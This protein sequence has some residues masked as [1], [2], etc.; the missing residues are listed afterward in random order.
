MVRE[1]KWY[2]YVG[3]G[4]KGKGKVSWIETYTEGSG[5]NQRTYSTER[6]S[7]E[8]YVDEVVIVWGDREAPEPTKL[9]PG[10][11]SFPFQ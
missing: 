11:F 1:S 5:S 10:T 8:S 6:Y 3:V 4:L 2:Q 7:Y 9:E